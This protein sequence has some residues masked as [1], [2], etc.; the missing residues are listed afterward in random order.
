MASFPFS[1][2]SFF[3][4]FSILAVTGCTP[5]PERFQK[6]GVYTKKMTQSNIPFENYIAYSKEKIER[7]RVDL[8]EDDKLNDTIIRANSPFQLTPNPS[9]CKHQNGSV[10]YKK[11]ILLIHGLTGS[12]YTMQD[13]G[14][15]FR[16]RCFLVRSILL[17]GHG[18]RPGDLLDIKYQD[19]VKSV[20][21]GVHSFAGLVDEMFLAG[22][23][24]GGTLAV[25]IWHPLRTYSLHT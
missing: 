13:L 24:L 5:L 18:T 7:H 1:I 12:P 19:W 4:L 3:S 6:S 20:D 16:N 15:F 11:G 14:K 21:Y 10:K 9:L 23:S 22:Y 17:P 2:I 8:T 25:C